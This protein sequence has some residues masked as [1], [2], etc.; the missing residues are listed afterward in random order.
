[1]KHYNILLPITANSPTCLTLASDLN[2]RGGREINASAL[3]KRSNGLLS[4]NSGQCVAFT[5]WHVSTVQQ[6]EKSEI[7]DRLETPKLR[8]GACVNVEK[9]KNSVL[10]VLS[11]L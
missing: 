9:R 1:L 6:V 8:F 11:F 2:G 3:N 5:L 7:T 10:L 4:L